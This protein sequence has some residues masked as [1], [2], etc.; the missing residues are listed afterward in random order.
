MV[1]T[2]EN[3]ST[4]NISVAMLESNPEIHRERPAWVTLRSGSSHPGTIIIVRDTAPRRSSL[5]SSDQKQ[6]IHQENPGGVWNCPI[7]LVAWLLVCRLQFLNGLLI[8]EQWWIG[9][10]ICRETTTWYNFSV[11]CSRSLI[12]FRCIKDVHALAPAPLD[13]WSQPGRALLIPS[14]PSWGVSWFVLFKNLVL[15]SEHFELV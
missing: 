2:G 8:C 6:C 12:I 14:G 3:R 9:F 5:I 15:S 13:S 1:V 11:H 7:V 10:S 4:R